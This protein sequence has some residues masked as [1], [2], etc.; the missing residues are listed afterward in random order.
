M[1][2][3]LL[4]SHDDIKIMKM[5]IITTIQLLEGKAGVKHPHTFQELWA[6]DYMTLETIRDWAVIQYNDSLR[7]TSLFA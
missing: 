4:I 7:P 2:N 5:S 6:A 1:L 3:P